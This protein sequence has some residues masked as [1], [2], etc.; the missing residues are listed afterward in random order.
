[1]GG[2][3]GRFFSSSG[4]KRYI[5]A[6][7]LDDVVPGMD[8]LRSGVIAV[9]REKANRRFLALRVGRHTTL[10]N[11]Q[12]NTF[13]PAILPSPCHDASSPPAFHHPGSVDGKV[14]LSWPGTPSRL[15]PAPA[16]PTARKRPNAEGAPSRPAAG[17]DEF[18]RGVTRPAHAGS[19][20]VQG[21][22]WF[23]LDDRTK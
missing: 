21:L 16:C 2:A 20:N 11:I 9:G 3:A 22:R 10:S 15:S 13:E 12:E 1:M 14:D 6:E 8:I 7:P 23:A 18:P 17:D 5:T 19:L 4:L